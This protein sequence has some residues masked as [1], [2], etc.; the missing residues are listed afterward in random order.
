[1]FKA[2][3]SKVMGVVAAAA[4]L[5]MAASSAH[6]VAV[7]ELSPGTLDASST[8]LSFIPGTTPSLGAF[9]NYFAFQITDPANQL[10][11]TINFVPAGAISPFTATLFNATCAV[12]GDCTLDSAAAS[13]AAN[14]A[15]EL[16]LDWTGVTAGYY[17]IEVAGTNLVG[18]GVGYS[19]QVAVR[20]AGV[21]LPGT[22]A[23]LGL[24]LS[25][26]AAARRRK[27]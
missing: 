18:S 27:A 3:V 19:G 7:T 11:S 21:P 17:V 1:M 9:T 25:G 22:V 6:A 14:S 13:F 16:K 4:G 8:Y 2:S 15:T 23:L 26:L 20:D 10:S 24:G 12:P 5:M